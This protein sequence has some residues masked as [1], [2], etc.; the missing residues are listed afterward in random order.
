MTALP[1]LHHTDDAHFEL[2]VSSAPLA[3]VV[4]SGAW[5]PPCRALEPTL[6]QLARDQIGRAHV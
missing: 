6:E 2:D 4:F 5:C 3:L 1:C